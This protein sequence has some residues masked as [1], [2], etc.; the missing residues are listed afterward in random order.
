M[1]KW[2][3]KFRAWAWT[4]EA[5]LASA[6]HVLVVNSFGQVELIV[7]ER[8]PL[9]PG[10]TLESLK[11]FSSSSR[12]P[13]AHADDHCCLATPP[14]SS[15]SSLVSEH[16]LG[17]KTSSEAIKYMTVLDYKCN[18]FIL[19]PAK[20][21]FAPILEWPDD[22]PQRTLSEALHG[23]PTAPKSNEPEESGELADDPTLVRQRLIFG[24]NVIEIGRVGLWKSLLDVVLHPFNLFQV[25]GVIIWSIQD[26]E[27]YASVIFALTLLSAIL[28]LRENRSTV[29]KMRRVARYVTMV[30]VWRG[31]RWMRM[32]SDELVPGDLVQLNS[33]DEDH[34]LTTVEQDKNS[35]SSH[36]KLIPFD[37]VLVNGDVLVDESLLTGESVP[38]LKE[39]VPSEAVF[40]SIRES[41]GSSQRQTTGFRETGK[42]MSGGIGGTS[43]LGSAR[44]NHHML[45]NLQCKHSL[46]AGTRLLRARA[47]QGKPAMV[48]VTRTGF[49][50]VKGSLV[51]SILFP[52]PNNF[53]FYRDTMTFMTVLGGIA[54]VGFVLA[55]VRLIS[56]GASSYYIVTRCLDLITV[57][58]PPALHTTMTIGTIFAI[59]RLKEDHRIYCI[60]PPKINV[61][62]LVNWVSFDKTGT[63]TEDGLDIVGVLPISSFIATDNTQSL[64]ALVKAK[65]GLITEQDRSINNLLYVMAA[66]HQVHRVRD[67][68]VGDPLDLKMFAWTGWE[69]AQASSNP[70]IMGCDLREAIDEEKMVVSDVQQG[71][72]LVVLKTFEFTP[73]LRKMSVIVL[74]RKPID[75]SPKINAEIEGSVLVLC[76]GSPEAIAACC[77]PETLPGNYAVVLAGYARSGYRVIACGA[78]TLPL[79]Q[80][81]QINSVVTREHA[82]SDLVFCG[83]MVCENALK[84]E[85]T[86]VISKLHAAAINTSMCTGDNVLTAVNVGRACGIIPPKALVFVASLR[87]PASS[88]ETQKHPNNNEDVSTVVQWEC[89]NN[90]VSGSRLQHDNNALFT[91][92]LATLTVR[93]SSS[94][95][96]NFEAAAGVYD[97]PVVLACTGD[98]LQQWLEQLHG[99]NRS[100]HLSDSE[101]DST[102]SPD[103]LELILDKC[104]IYARMSPADK[105]LLVEL[106]QASGKRCVAFVGDGPNDIG[107]LKAADVGLS[108]SEAEASVAAPFTSQH[109][110]IRCVVNVIREGRASL[111]TSFSAFKFMA[112][113]SMIQFTSIIFLYW[114][115]STLA[116][117]Q[118][119]YIDLMMVLPL[120]LLMARFGTAKEL[121]NTPPTAKLIS[122]TV[123]LSILGQT[124]LQALI[125]GAAAVFTSRLPQVLARPVEREPLGESPNV[126]LPENTSIFI[127]SMF[128]YVTLAMLYCGTAPHRR[129][130]YLPFQAWLVLATVVN[131]LIGVPGWI[132]HLDAVYNGLFGGLA[133]L[134]RSWLWAPL[135]AFFERRTAESFADTF[136]FVEIPVNHRWLMV[137]LALVHFIAACMCEWGLFPLI[138]SR[139]NKQGNASH[140]LS[141]KAM[142][143]V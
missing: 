24:K 119:V 100:M 66:C 16:E 133:H 12:D 39:T 131:V 81:S 61:G 92:D 83:F 4:R 36:A 8:V 40:A 76:K 114:Q 85:T 38:V 44:N 136:Q 67:H 127:T 35:A 48:L 137:S 138:L 53:R 110:D 86:P 78:K 17:K 121:H 54:I 6:D 84:P 30:S 91:L 15:S 50:T 132:A 118:F 107:A 82:E 126:E 2:L 32:A 109:R 26:Y 64:P 33:Q 103:W 79:L 31:Q 14:S 106:M 99:N 19:D 77:R 117:F 1:A 56:L 75:G 22:I 20:G 13:E 9:P 65:H 28:T 93:P 37:G 59:A 108:L 129:R 142:A 113:Y 27:L 25:A 112:M 41:Y 125:Q 88:S 134:T 52:R 111:A 71:E 80:P 120:S 5:P 3:P 104:R 34:S 74:K 58:V 102:K 69:M 98:V 90:E 60:S 45:I 87:S 105:Q 49:L 63:L 21:I 10:W 139:V 140:L 57:V 62:A 11:T 95:A 130:L 47:R 97:R 7:L 55:L 68:F 70:N 101:D 23:L 122:P 135:V 94:K 123:L 89:M 73:V 116:D 43:S 46:F 42:T 18:R 29:E 72:E 51:Q 143:P 124:A 141:I 128:L 115:G 96:S